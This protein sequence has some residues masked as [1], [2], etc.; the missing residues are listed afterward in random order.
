MANFDYERNK[1]TKLQEQ[2]AALGNSTNGGNGSQIALAPILVAA[3][4][5]ARDVFRS[6]TPVG[7]RL[8]EYGNNIAV[9]HSGTGPG[10]IAL[11]E[12]VIRAIRE[13]ERNS[14]VTYFQTAAPAPI[15]VAQSTTRD[16]SLGGSMTRLQRMRWT[17]EWFN[18]MVSTNDNNEL[19]AKAI[20]E[21][22]ARIVEVSQIV[23]DEL[24]AETAIAA[25]IFAIRM[26]M[27]TNH[28][29]PFLAEAAAMVDV[30]IIEL[31]RKQ[32]PG[33]SPAQPA[34]VAREPFISLSRIAE[35]RSVPRH[36]LDPTRLVR[37]LEEIN[38][39]YE[40]NCLLS[41]A[42]LCRS[43]MNHIPP[44]FDQPNFAAVASSHGGA[45]LKG[46]MQS[47]QTSLKHIA[48]GQT[49][50]QMRSTESLPEPQQINFGPAMDKL[51]EEVIRLLKDRATKASTPG[52]GTP[53][54]GNAQ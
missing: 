30:A 12:D 38:E 28:P 53:R 13:K 29:R 3:A 25:Q 6:D 35:L 2:I 4:N 54:I 5:V 43:V 11:I 23:N 41:V 1:L 36:G 34:A 44:V 50:E 17:R 27:T 37:F 8:V 22:R 32:I 51:L 45:S 18:A 52:I 42:I 20:G 24:G 40:R 47:L 7:T 21:I 14:N 46:A 9:W 26:S 19:D 49:H 33:K 39:N 15:V 48:D 16:T 10:A 31:E